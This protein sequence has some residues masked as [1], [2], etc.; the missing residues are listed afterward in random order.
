MDSAS[1]TQKLDSF[2]IGIVFQRGIQGN[3][4]AVQPLIHV[5]DFP[6]GY[7]QRSR[8]QLRFG[9]ESLV[10]QLLFFF[11]Q[12]EKQLALPLGGSDFDQA[13]VV[14]DEFEDI[15]LDPEGSIVGKF[16]IFVGIEFFDGL[17]EPDVALL[18]QIQ[19][20]LH[21]DPLKFERNFHH[22]PEV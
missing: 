18:N 20:V 10:D 1:V 2:R 13:P 9:V 8:Q 6:F 14:H 15:G 21:P 16:D 7:A 11:F 5:D 19:K 17:H 22:Q 4:P 12:L 3:V